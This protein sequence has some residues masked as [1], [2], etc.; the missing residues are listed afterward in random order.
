MTDRDR[1]DGRAAALLVLLCALWG[2][3]SV[4]IK[5]TNDS[6]PPVLQAGMRS[7][8]AA[9]L[10]RAWAKG[11]DIPLFEPDGT[12][13]QGLAV[14]ALFGVEFAVLFEALALASASHVVLFLYSAPFFVAL[15][16]QFFLP[17][18]RLRPW[19]WLGL[20]CAFAGMALGFGD[21]LGA[22]RRDE[23]LGTALALLAGF[24]WGATTVLI[25]AGKL[26][27]ATPE[28]TL[29]YQLVVSALILPAIS[30]W[31]GEVWPDGVGPTGLASIAF[32]AIGVAFASY[33][34]WFWLIR[35]YPAAKVSSFTFL[36]PL[37]GVLAGGL[38]L[39]EALSPSLAVALALVA[40]GI[41]LVN[42]RQPVEVTQQA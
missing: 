3:Q 13:W 18:E 11:R 8:V 19:Q 7:A 17:G 26:A 9:L 20:A 16:T 6:I 39:G 21:A 31:Y 12:L 42:R 33:L 25:K 10:L 2:V 30:L 24:L 14:G 4:A 1:I 22:M 29:F 41:Y 32:Q 15:G 36:T 34:A 40:L 27:R 35:H 38:L 37:F 28:K 5:L 23:V